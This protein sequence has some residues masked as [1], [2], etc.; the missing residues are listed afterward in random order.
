MIGMFLLN[1]MAK[2]ALSLEAPDPGSHPFVVIV[3]QWPYGAIV[4]A[5]QVK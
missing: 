2:T 4:G 5:V 1:G 3:Q